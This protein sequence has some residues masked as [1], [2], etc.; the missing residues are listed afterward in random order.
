MYVNRELVRRVEYS[1]ADM[2]ARQADVLARMTPMT[3]G[4]AHECDGGQLIAFGHGRYVNR[5]AGIG[6]GDMLATEI[7]IAVESFYKARSLPASVEIN[8]WVNADLVAAL[9]DAGFRLERFRNVYV[10]ELASLVKTKTLDFS[11]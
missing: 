10:H 8:P 1:A 2:S 7:V 4:A 11:I 5:A 6:L 9:G 3:P